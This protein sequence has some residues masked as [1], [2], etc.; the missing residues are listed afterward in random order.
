MIYW[1]QT[2]D[3]WCLCGTFFCTQAIFK[4]YTV[5]ALIN[6]NVFPAVFDIVK[7]CRKIHAIIFLILKA[8]AEDI[9]P[10]FIKLGFDLG[11]IKA[12]YS[13]FPNAIV[14]GYQFH[15]WQSGM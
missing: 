5:S 13:S 7:I 14:I 3:V 15:L 10:R 11:S 8:M 9:N 12:L 4:L 2:K 6:N 1:L